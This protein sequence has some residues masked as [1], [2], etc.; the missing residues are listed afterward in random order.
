MTQ[1]AAEAGAAPLGAPAG[2]ILR[3]LHTQ[4]Q[5]E[6]FLTRQ[7]EILDG[8]RWAEWLELF[9]PDG[10]YWMP[11]DP[12]QTSGEG[13]PSIFYEDRWLMR[14]RVKR[15][16]HP[17]AWSQSPPNRTSHVVGNVVVERDDPVGGEVVARAKFHVV[18]FRLDS[19][20]HFA[21]SYRH[22]LVR[23][24]DGFL[25]RLQRVDIVNHDGPFDYVLQFWI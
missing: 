18:E 4:W 20:R 7:A 11:A 6:Q 12:S 25:I 22:H 2:D 3:R 17:R 15:L 14:T 23:S 24:G 5:V 16:E 10:H 1:A 19:Q 21:G 9:A 8:R 13:V